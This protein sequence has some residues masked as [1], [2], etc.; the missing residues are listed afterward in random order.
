MLGSI[1]C[2]RFM[3]D[4]KFR[5]FSLLLALFAAEGVFAE[6]VECAYAARESS[7]H[8][9]P[10]EQEFQPRGLCG[11][12]QP[13]GTLVVEPDFLNDI[14]FSEGLGSV[15]VSGTGWFYVKSNGQ[16]AQ[17]LT[18]DNGPDYFNEGLARTKPAGKIG[19]IDSSLSEVIPAKWDFAFPFSGGYAAVCDGC[20]KQS[21]DG[22]HW[23]IQGGV[24]GRIS[25][26]GK[27]VVP[28][29]YGPGELPPLP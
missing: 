15:F 1:E 18:H 4:L 10:Y 29:K 8:P 25:R 19:F 22:E 17:V 27:V 2:L 7:R 16:T 5:L 14:D 11:L 6:S 21:A 28:V 3:I 12:L 23:E 20:R 9:T 26:S 24:W 13:D